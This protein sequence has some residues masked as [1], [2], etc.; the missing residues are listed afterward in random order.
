MYVST[1]V[2]YIFGGACLYNIVLLKCGPS[3]T[4]QSIAYI[5]GC[6]FYT[7]LVIVLFLV[8][9][10]F[11]QV[12]KTLSERKL[13]KQNKNLSEPKAKQNSEEESGLLQENAGG[14]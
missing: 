12:N 7:I 10:H 1:I 9:K 5:S 2:G 13:T 4:S 3:V 8:E 11:F 6:I 14:W